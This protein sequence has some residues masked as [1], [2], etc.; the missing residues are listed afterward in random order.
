VKIRDHVRGAG[1]DRII[2]KRIGLVKKQD[3]R[4]WTGF[5]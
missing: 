1:A 4:V 5:N 2:L 3:A